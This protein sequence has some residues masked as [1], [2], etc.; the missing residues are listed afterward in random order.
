MD[1]LQFNNAARGV[2]RAL[3]LT[4]AEDRQAIADDFESK[5]S[6]YINQLTHLYN[7]TPKVDLENLQ[8]I[9]V[10]VEL[11]LNE[12]NL[13]GI[14]STINFPPKKLKTIEIVMPTEKN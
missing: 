10:T 2:A 6:P 11:T 12:K 14:L 13:P 5:N 7:A 8:S 1:Y 4:P 3:A 9:K